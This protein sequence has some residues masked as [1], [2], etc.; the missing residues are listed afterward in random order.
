MISSLPHYSVWWTIPCLKNVTWGV[1]S[2]QD[3]H[4]LQPTQ[5]TA[6]TKQSLNDTFQQLKNNS[7]EVA[8]IINEK[9]SKYLKNPKKKEEMKA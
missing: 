8:L 7:M 3:S 6:R 2:P 4:K 9:K 1:T 5:M